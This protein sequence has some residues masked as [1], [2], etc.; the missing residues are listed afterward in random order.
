MHQPVER[1]HRR[2]RRLRIE[3]D[4]SR[5]SCPRDMVVDPYGLL[6]KACSWCLVADCARVPRMY[7]LER[8]TSWREV[9]QPRRIRESRTLTTVA[10]ALIAQWEY[11]HAIEVSATIDQT[12]I[13]RNGSSAYDSSGTTMKNPPPATR[14]PSASCIW[15]TCEHC[16]RSEAPSLCTAPPK[17]GLTFAT[18]PPTLPTTM[19][20]HQR[21]DPQQLLIT[22]ARS[23]R[24][25]PGSAFEFLVKPL[26]AALRQGLLLTAR[27]WCRVACFPSTHIRNERGLS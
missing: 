14:Q 24:A 11:H 25:M 23:A 3:Y 1:R 13:E 4:S 17:P 20:R 8:I 2:G 19:R 27:I 12:Q 26:A 22:P 21:P 9:E 10:A 15:R 5:E 16:C 6:A 7:R 18:S